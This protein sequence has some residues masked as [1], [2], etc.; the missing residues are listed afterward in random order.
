MNK[1]NTSPALTAPILL[2]FLSN[3]SN[4]D[5]VASIANLG[6]SIFSQRNKNF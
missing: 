5:Q 1:V 6:Y 2:I 3:S 4:T